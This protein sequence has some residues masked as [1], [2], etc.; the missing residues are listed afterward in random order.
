M[1]LKLEIA[2]QIERAAEMNGTTII[3]EFQKAQKKAT[4]AGMEF[5]F[6]TIRALITFRKE[7]QKPLRE[8]VKSLPKNN[9]DE[10][11]S[12]FT[13][14]SLVI[15]KGARE[16]Y[17]KGERVTV[18]DDGLRAKDARTAIEGDRRR[19]NKE[20][21]ASWS[22]MFDSF[23]TEYLRG[24]TQEN[25]KALVKQYGDVVRKLVHKELTEYAK[26]SKRNGRDG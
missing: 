23:L 11:E 15:D 18:R 10:E 24:P 21:G 16:V 17:R 14:N 22:G 25:R 4:A 1:A 13:S 12:P 6:P 3:S 2:A 9:E 26:R 20:D 5:P 19:D 7:Q 8:I